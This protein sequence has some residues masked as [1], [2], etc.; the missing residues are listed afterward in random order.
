MAIVRIQLSFD[1][2][3]ADIFDKGSAAGL[4]VKQLNEVLAGVNALKAWRPELEATHGSLR[5]IVS[6]SNPDDPPDMI[7]E[8]DS[9]SLTVEITDINPHPYGQAQA[10]H[11][12]EMPNAFVSL[13]ALSIPNQTKTEIRQA[14]IS[15]LLPHAEAV[16]DRQRHLFQV[17]KEQIGRKGRRV[18]AKRV[19][20]DI[21]VLNDQSLFFDSDILPLVRSLAAIRK[22]RALPISDSTILV[23]H[24][25]SNCMQFR[26]FVIDAL[27]QV[28]ARSA[29][30]D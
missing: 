20:L 28:K 10:I 8:F 14:M 26:S 24:S 16:G 1:L 29:G 18:A 12:D 13:P 19:E 7:F 30:H 21:L 25:E 11:R 3:A 23:V 2:E 27:G 6:R 15:K 4:E 17:T 9:K 22:E 5:A